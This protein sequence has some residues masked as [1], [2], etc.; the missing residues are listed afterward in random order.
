MNIS[1]LPEP[2][3]P[4]EARVGITIPSYMEGGRPVRIASR[5]LDEIPES[6]VVIVDHSDGTHQQLLCGA[7][8][9]LPSKKKERIHLILGSAKTG[10][11]SAVLEGFA[12]LH[13][14]PAGVSFFCEM[15]SDG[16][17]QVEDLARYFRQGIESD[18]VIGSRY[19]PDSQIVG[20][21]WARRRFSRILNFAI[22]LM[23][24]LK[25]SD[26]TNGLRIYSRGAVGDLLGLN[27]RTT[28]FIFLTESL[29]HLQR[30]GHSVREEPSIFLQR[31][32]G[33]SS[34]GAKE[35]YSALKGL[36]QILASEMRSRS[37]T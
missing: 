3:N 9:A 36:F 21:S 20:W 32:S 33:Q 35:I 14:L 5:L 10:R 22:P 6:I 18:I 7:L 15:D 16:S 12:T 27:A 8:G 2:W 31:E 17:H 13:R 34:V 24:D 30:L 23:L 25:V 11:G 4:L 37:S 28:T 26:I 29:V 19:L 1:Q